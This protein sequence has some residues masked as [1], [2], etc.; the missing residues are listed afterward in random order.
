MKIQWVRSVFSY[1]EDNQLTVEVFQDCLN[2][3]ENISKSNLPK[4]SIRARCL[5]VD[6]L[7]RGSILALRFGE[8]GTML[9]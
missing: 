8:Q 5:I 9:R 3:L 6:S 4:W 1:D 7:K 2:I